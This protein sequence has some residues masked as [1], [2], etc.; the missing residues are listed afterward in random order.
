[1]A[2][3]QQLVALYRDND[4]KAQF[5]SNYLSAKCSSNANWTLSL[6]QLEWT[7]A[8]NILANDLGDGY[9]PA[10]SQAPISKI[11]S[12]FLRVSELGLSFN[13][14][15]KEIYLHG[16]LDSHNNVT[17]NTCLGYKGMQK[18][19]M[20]TGSFQ[21]FTT[22]LVHEGDTFNWMGS[23]DKPVF[24]SSGKTAGMDL[25]CGIVVFTYRNGSVLSY[26]MD[27]EELLAIESADLE[28]HQQQFGSAG[29]SLYSGPWRNRM[30]KISLWRN[31]YNELKHILMASANMP[32][33]N[34]D[35]YGV[36]SDEQEVNDDFL[37]AFRDELVSGNQQD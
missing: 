25:I 31:A 18:L 34:I 27:A 35:N 36:F 30:L 6:A 3:R 17:L 8:F 32:L 2:D 12:A 10:V 22:E 9:R 29:Y 24:V 7:N 11:R 5:I 28:R 19:V 13:P 20:N 16:A 26:K 4:F 14:E 23:Q 1:M 21:Y 37:N 15:T 33:L